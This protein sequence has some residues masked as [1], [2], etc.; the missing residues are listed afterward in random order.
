LSAFVAPLADYAN[1]PHVE[2]VRRITSKLLPIALYLI[3]STGCGI[4]LGILVAIGIVT[5]PLRFIVKH[6]WV[7]DLI[8]RDRRRGITTVYVMTTTM[9]DN[10]VLMYRGRLHE[11][12]L[13]EDGKLSYVIL[14]DCAR[15]YM[16]FG[17]D[18]LKTTA[19][20]DIFRGATAQRRIWDYLMIDGGNIANILFDPSAQSIKATEE[21]TRAL[22][23]AVKAH[24]E[25]VE[26]AKRA[27][28]A[29]VANNPSI[30]G[31]QGAAKPRQ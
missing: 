6:K 27:A 3:A 31:Q 22:I 9:E 26:R 12:F 14:K 16:N 29:S 11:F 25:S 1:V 23:A 8:D 15:Y 24:R 2:L 13:L 28:A 17:D 30:A 21:G 5:G 18:E 10:K 19:Q 4:G 20:L 7:Y